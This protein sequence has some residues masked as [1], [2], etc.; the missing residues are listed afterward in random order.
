MAVDGPSETSR[1]DGPDRAGGVGAADGGVGAADAA[2]ISAAADGVPG[3][4]VVAEA[5][6]VTGP[7]AVTDGFEVARPAEGGVTPAGAPDPAAAV[8][9][10]ATPAAPAVDNP[11]AF[12]ADADLSETEMRER[13]SGLSTPEL[14]DVVT[15]TDQADMG[16]GS[17]V[18]EAGRAALNAEISS[19][20]D[21]AARAQDWT[22]PELADLSAATVR[23]FGTDSPWA[24][25]SW[26]DVAQTMTDPAVSGDP[27]TAAAHETLTATDRLMQHHVNGDVPVAQMSNGQLMRS[28][29]AIPGMQLAG[30]VLS[31]TGPGIIAGFAAD[32]RAQERLQELDRRIADGR[33]TGVDPEALTTRDWTKVAG[34]AV[35]AAEIGSMVTPQGWLRNGL[36]S[37]LRGGA[38][39][40]DDVAEA[41]ARR[42]APV[43][44][45]AARLSG[46]ARELAAERALQARGLD[47][48]RWNLEIGDTDI[49]L[50]MSTPQG[51]Y[52]VLVGGDAK[53]LRNGVIDEDLVAH[54]L[55]RYRRARDVVTDADGPLRAD[56]AGVMMAFPRGTDQ[57]VIDRFRQEIGAHN[58]LVF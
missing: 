13:L 55:E 16:F 1:A 33:M 56:G 45:D 38:R 36:E 57:R 42:G 4:D 11:A 21:A 46:E 44:G 22:N 7:D 43:G 27:G 58:V 3:D 39:H 47:A 18:T 29:E 35:L 14:T 53:A 30:D 6:N 49:D 19:R 37:V 17:R 12:L 23:N 50:L 2:D 25:K 24:E 31:L 26:R 52:G 51:R 28:V 9:E 34:G 20:F 40:A 32:A 54:S 5:R 41:A 8:T 48:R 15:G 10:V